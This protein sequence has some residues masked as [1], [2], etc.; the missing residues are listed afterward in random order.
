MANWKYKLELR[1]LKDKYEN[2]ELSIENLGTEMGKRLRNLKL[3]LEDKHF[4][5]DLDSVA[6][7]FETTCNTVENFDNILNDLL[8]RY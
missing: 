8:G 2:D 1:D 7:D 5:G 3:E 6:E 4:Q